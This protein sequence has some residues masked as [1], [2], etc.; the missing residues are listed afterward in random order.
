M[1]EMSGLQ[2][3][4]RTIWI[5][6]LQGLK[7]APRVVTE[8]YASWRRLNP[9]WEIVFLDD[10]N[11]HEYVDLN[12]VRAKQ[13]LMELPALSDIIRIKLLEKY[14]GVWVDA[15]CFCRR[16]LDTWL[17]EATPSGFFLFTKPVPQSLVA[18]WFIAARKDNHLI[19]AWAK[20]AEQYILESPNLARRV[21]IARWFKW[22]SNNVTVTRYYFSFPVRRIFKFY[23]YYWFMYLFAEVIRKDRRAREIWNAMPKRPV[24]NPPGFHQT[25][26]LNALTE[27]MKSA[28]DS[29]E[30]PML[31]L[32]RHHKGESLQKGSILYYV[33]SLNN[34]PIIEIA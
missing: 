19:K 15:T 20:A 33:Y 22:F 6:W 23:H 31:K 9:D 25:T 26:F 13:P 5:L 2:Q 27:N 21:K 14:G 8:C 12:D 18:V 30:L 11:L 29:K 32:S 16:P 7:N 34:E 4:P 24:P 3:I 10:S 1:H 17:E 28:I